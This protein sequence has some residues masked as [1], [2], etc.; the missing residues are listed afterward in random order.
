MVILLELEESRI[1]TR[2]PLGAKLLLYADIYHRFNAHCALGLFHLEGAC[3]HNFCLPF[4]VC[5][6]ATLVL[7]LAEPITALS[8]GNGLSA[9][10]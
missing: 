1:S 5:I 3:F 9:T 10:L 7:L 4:V 8:S 6:A 2:E